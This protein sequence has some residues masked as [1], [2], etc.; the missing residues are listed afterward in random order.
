MKSLSIA[1]LMAGLLIQTACA[2]APSPAAPAPPAARPL[3]DARFYQ[4][5]WHEIG[6]PRMRITDGCVAGA[7]EYTRLDARRVRV[8]DTCRQGGPDGPERAVT[9]AGYLLDPPA[10]ARLA[11]R[12]FG[13][14]RWE[15]RVLDHDDAYSWFIS[16][17]PA[18][19]NLWIYT[20][21][22]APS[23]ALVDDLTRRAAALGYDARRLEFP[24]AP[25]R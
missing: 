25:F 21:D 22:P 20:R 14:V 11:V 4:G 9:G 16:A 6:R 7:T 18:F 2:S 12:Y 15:Y 19:T 1:A 24:D 3:D 17:N 23:Q 13:V 10:N 5:R 8:R